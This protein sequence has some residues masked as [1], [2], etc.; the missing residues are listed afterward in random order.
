MMRSEGTYLVTGN[1]KLFPINP[2]VV[3][4]A[5]IVDIMKDSQVSPNNKG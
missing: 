1:I 3:T 4:P 2:I 5:Q